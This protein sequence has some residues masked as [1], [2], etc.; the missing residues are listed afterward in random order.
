MFPHYIS[1]VAQQGTGHDS[2]EGK[3][4]VFVRYKGKHGYWPLPR[5]QAESEKQSKTAC[6]HTPLSDPLIMHEL[7]RSFP[8]NHLRFI[9]YPVA[10]TQ[11]MEGQI[12]VV[13]NDPCSID[14]KSSLRSAIITPTTA[15]VVPRRDSHALVKDSHFQEVTAL[16]SGNGGGCGLHRLPAAYTSNGLIVEIPDQIPQGII[17]V[18]SIGI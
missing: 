4:Q 1:Q 6:S 18:E 7:G 8:T 15:V 17:P 13:V 2:R 10:G 9:D 11:D 3:A 5:P 16:G 12:G 14:E